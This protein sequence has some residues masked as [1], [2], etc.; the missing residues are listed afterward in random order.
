MANTIGS[1]GVKQDIIIKQGADFG[2]YALTI[3]DA[4]GVPMNL[5][6]FT[7]R[8]II[9]VRPDAQRVI[10]NFTF[11]DVDLVNGR[12]NMWIPN[13]ETAKLKG[14]IDLTPRYFYD[15]SMEDASGIIEPLMYGTV[16]VYPNA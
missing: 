6:G 10:I 16:A 2:K 14:N 3:K 12:I 15:V 8:G 5:T 13:T 11:D 9:K 1:I 4:S 7:F